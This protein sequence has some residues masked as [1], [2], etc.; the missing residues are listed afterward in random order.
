M[1][2]VYLDF[3]DKIARTGV[4]IAK[5]GHH[6]I[7]IPGSVQMDVK[8]TWFRLCVQVIQLNPTNIYNMTDKEYICKNEFFY[9]LKLIY[10]LSTSKILKKINS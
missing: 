7:L 1:Q 8:T 4:E 6:A 5:L 9:N 2:S 10:N 3:L